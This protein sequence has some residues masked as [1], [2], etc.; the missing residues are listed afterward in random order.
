MY[1]YNYVKCYT[2]KYHYVDNNAHRKAALISVQEVE[3]Y[4]R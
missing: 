2:Q 1:V 3:S 4:L